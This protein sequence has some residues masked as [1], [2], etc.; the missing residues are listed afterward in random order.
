MPL[1]DRGDRGE[2]T[3]AASELTEAVEA[4]SDGPPKGG[5]HVVYYD[6]ELDDLI[7]SRVVRRTVSL[8]F[9]GRDQEQHDARSWP[10]A[11]LRQNGQQTRPEARSTHSRR[12]TVSDY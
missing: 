12:S 3:D 7:K 11:G 1:T 8:R 4:F 10:R 2:L 5:E 9:P 6:P